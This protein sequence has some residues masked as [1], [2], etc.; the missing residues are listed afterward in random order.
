[1]ATLI[2]ITLFA[3]TVAVGAIVG[4]IRGLNKSVIRFMTFAVAVI[5]TFLVAAPITNAIIG[6]LGLEE[7]IFSAL[8]EAESAALLDTVPQLAGMLTA[9]PGLV[10]GIV[11]FPVVFVMLNFISWIVFLCIQKPLRKAIFKETFGKK[12]A[13]AAEAVPLEGAVENMDLPAV[14]VPAPSR[15]ARIGKRFAGMGIG[16]VTGVLIFAM[17]LTPTLGVFSMLPKADSTEKML[18]AMV[19]RDL[20]AAGDAEMILGAY[21]VTDNGLVNFY[22]AIGF[23]SAGKAYLNAVS[24][25]EVNGQTMYLCQELGALMNIVQNVL[26]DDRLL[27]ALGS[28]DPNALFDLLADKEFMDGLMGDLLGS[29]VLSGLVPEL[30]SMAMEGVAAGMNV[31]ANSE[32]VYNN[33]MDDVALAVRDAAVDYD[34]IAAYEQANNIRSG[35]DGSAELMT[36]EEYEAE[37]AKLVEL[38]ETIAEILNRGL[39]GDH[40]EFTAAAAQHI[41]NEVRVRSAE[42]GAAAL[43]NFDAAGVQNALSNM[44]AENVDPALL[45]QLQ[46]P[47]KFETDVATVETIKAAIVE[48]VKNALADE[49]KAAETASTLASVVSDL[50]GAVA[51]A[52]DEEGNLDAAKLDYSKIGDAVTTLQN[53]VLKDVGSSLLDIVVSGDLGKNEMVGSMMESIKEGYENG[54]DV[55]GTIGTAGD[56]INLGNAMS[57]EG[58]QDKE[59]VVDS[60]TSLIENLNEFT[61][62]LLPDILS[63]EALADMGVPAEYAK[64]TFGIFETLLKEL[65]KLQGAEDYNNEVQSIL[66]L[67]DLATSGVANFSKEHIADLAGYANASDAVFNTLMSIS[68]SN[69]FGIEIPDESARNDL[70]DSIEELYEAS[71]RTQREAQIYTAI[72]RLLGIDEYVELK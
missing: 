23:G 2:L 48:T 1:M 42:N 43:E 47:S 66:S 10:V 17:L 19:S 72:A 36:Q 50:A 56:L 22:G 70:V 30:V 31:P 62:S 8:E 54:E 28:E 14:E 67:Y 37:I 61:I 53:S 49:S 15:G 26:G 64:T 58:G 5:L 24:K 52:M 55:G 18:D 34:G 33:M 6:N 35:R 44:E 9:L 20:L 38:T 51:S 60:L 29:K 16:I 65:L 69:P 45:E 27:S 40:G 21:G 63:D 12:D 4:L 46:D 7:L 3:V 41:V 68:D 59:A 25:F 13:P 39:A 57:G 71:G 11:V 32:A